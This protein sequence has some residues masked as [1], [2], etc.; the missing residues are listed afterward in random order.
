MWKHLLRNNNNNNNNNK[1]EKRR[2]ILS[3][4]TKNNTEIRPEQLQKKNG[5]K[6]NSVD[7]LSD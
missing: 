6:Y 3:T 1:I 2:G 7:V 5:W 4:A